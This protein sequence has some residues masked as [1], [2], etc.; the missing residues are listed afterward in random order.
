MHRLR[1]IDNHP[2]S[3]DQDLDGDEHAAYYE[4]RTGRDEGRPLRAA[5]T[6]VKDSRYS[7][8]LR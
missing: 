6:R 5:L 3:V 8:G 4:L 7:V 1:R 2:N